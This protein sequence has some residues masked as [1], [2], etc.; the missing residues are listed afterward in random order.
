MVQ[1]SKATVQAAERENRPN[2]AI[3]HLAGLLVYGFTATYLVIDL[4]SKV[5]SNVIIEVINF[6]EIVP[7]FS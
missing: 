7:L 4:V 1:I 6:L 5:D 3:V 2:I